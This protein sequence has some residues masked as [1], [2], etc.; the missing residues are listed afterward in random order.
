MAIEHDA[1][2]AG[3]ELTERCQQEANNI[4]SKMVAADYRPNIQSIVNDAALLIKANL[5]NDKQAQVE[6]S[7]EQRKGPEIGPEKLEM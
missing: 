6:E 1:Q 3:T 5:N 7:M 4:S 2:V